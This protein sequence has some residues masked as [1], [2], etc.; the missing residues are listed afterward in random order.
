MKWYEITFFVVE[1]FGLG[2]CLGLYFG[3]KWTQRQRDK[4][5]RYIKTK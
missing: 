4:K 5:G 3:E 1:A 2:Y